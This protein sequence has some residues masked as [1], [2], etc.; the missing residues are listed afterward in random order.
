MTEGEQ[1]GRNIARW[2]HANPLRAK[3]VA[4][5]IVTAVVFGCIFMTIDIVRHGKWFKALFIF[6]ISAFFVLK[7]LRARGAQQSRSAK[8]ANK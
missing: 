1:I 6:S 5:L 2:F 4:W 8:S 3:V 7:V